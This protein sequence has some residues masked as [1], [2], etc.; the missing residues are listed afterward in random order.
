MLLPT[1]NFTLPHEL[2][3]TAPIEARGLPRD[4]VRLLVSHYN[5]DAVE[6]TQFFN[7]TDHLDEGDVVIINTSATLPAAVRGL[8]RSGESGR[9]AEVELHFSTR[10]SDNLHV[11]ELRTVTPNGTK[12]FYYADAGDQV[13]LPANAALDL[14]E[15]Y[16]GKVQRGGRVRLWL[17]C[18]DSAETFQ[19]WLNRVG[20]PIRYS[21]V[22]EQ[23]SLES[24]QTVF[25]NEPG[26]AEMPSAGRAF[27]PLLITQLVAKGVQFAPIVLHTG[28]ASLEDHEPPY[29][30]YFRVSAHSAQTINRAIAAGRRIVAIGTTAVRAVESVVDENGRV[31][32][33]EGWTERLISAENPPQVVN[34]LLTGFHEPEATHLAMLTAISGEQ[35][36]R[37]TYT[38]ALNERYLWHEFGDLHLILP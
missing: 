37:H 22:P 8:H 29:A 18:L 30:E 11:V 35:H 4:A 28:V 32:A 7:L 10:L 19:T 14:I 25:A 34:G 5:N 9:E 24:Y 16:Q 31:M 1:I 12:P 15:P 6:H 20:F 23:W 33:G 17:A 38:A 27:S 36:I 21:Y 13:Q 26:S 2:E 3:A